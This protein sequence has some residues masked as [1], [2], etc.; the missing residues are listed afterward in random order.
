MT[1]IRRGG[2]IKERDR[3]SRQDWQAVRLS[4][5]NVLAGQSAKTTKGKKGLEELC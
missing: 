2:N 4:E 1:Q 3:S 5:G